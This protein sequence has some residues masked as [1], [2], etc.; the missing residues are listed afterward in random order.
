MGCWGANTEP[1]FFWI[2]SFGAKIH[3]KERLNWGT[4][5]HS[6]MLPHPHIHTQSVTLFKTKL[7]ESKQLSREALKAKISHRW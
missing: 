2:S 1:R 4:F 6:L 7:E 3:P 5:F